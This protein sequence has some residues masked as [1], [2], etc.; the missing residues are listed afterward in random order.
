[1]IF[2]KI[3]RNRETKIAEIFFWKKVGADF[4]TCNKIRPSFKNPTKI[5]FRWFN[6]EKLVQAENSRSHN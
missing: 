4:D 5:G 3:G 1:M 2:S 6:S